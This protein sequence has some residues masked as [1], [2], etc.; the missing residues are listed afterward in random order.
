MATITSRITADQLAAMPDDGRRYELIDGELKVMSPAGGEHGQIAAEFCWRVGQFVR[1]NQLGSVFAAE[2]GFLIGRN[3]DTVR[4]PD[5]AF[6]T[7]RR[8]DAAGRVTGYWPG[9]PDIAAEV[10]SPGDSFAD[11]EEKV[12]CWLAAATQ[13]VWAIEP[14]QRH[15]TVYRSASDITVLASAVSLDAADL[16]PGWS[17]LVRDLFPF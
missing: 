5:F 3:P 16:L 1:E 11:V 7:R 4:A 6:V 2:T 13:V 14:R 10:I 12:L 8:C 9:A 15:V 17:M